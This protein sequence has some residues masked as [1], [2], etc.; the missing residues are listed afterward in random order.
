MVPGGVA[1]YAG[2]SP[3]SVTCDGRVS[4]VP[5]RDAHPF[6]NRYTARVSHRY[7]IRVPHPHSAGDGHPIAHLYRYSYR[8]SE[9][10]YPNHDCYRDALASRD[11]NRHTAAPNKHDATTCRAAASCTDGHGYRNILT[12][13]HRRPCGSIARG[14]HACSVAGGNQD[15]PTVNGNSYGYPAFG[16][17]EP[18]SV[19]TPATIAHGGKGSADC[20]ANT[21]TAGAFASHEGSCPT[22]PPAQAASCRTDTPDPRAQQ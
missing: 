14:A 2:S 7:T 5:D 20:H 21:V 15:A 1:I 18:N 19:H 11:G 6:G 4:P 13:V 16:D 17:A 12:G 22:A 9:R 8:Y 10:S 3:I